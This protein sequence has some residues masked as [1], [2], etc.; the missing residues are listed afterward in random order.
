M[1]IAAD[2]PFRFPAT[3]TFVVRAFSV[4]DG[5]GKGLDPRFD[6]TE[7]A[8]PYALELLR[9]REAGVE[10]I[11][12]DFRK[13]WDRQ[14]RAFYN[15]FRQAG[16]VEKL[17]QIIERLEKGDLKLRVRALESERA[18]QRVAVVQKTIGCALVAGTLVNLA[19]I[20]YLHSI[21]MPAIIAYAVSALF[22]LQALFGVLKVKK[23]DEME[24]L[25]TGTA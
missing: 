3:F 6:I 13:G 7:I 17:A 14:S 19:T 16:R 24:R 12:K 20:L 9:F 4:L 21:R 25:I 22:G 5:I 2:Q 8:K 10:I 23:L 15:L 11:L 18:F 1:A